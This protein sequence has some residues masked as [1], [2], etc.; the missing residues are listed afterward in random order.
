LLFDRGTKFGLESGGIAE[1]VLVSMPLEARWEFGE[2]VHWKAIEE[3]ESE[4]VFQQ[5]PRNWLDEEQLNSE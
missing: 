1:N 5:E 4:R 3:I 2:F